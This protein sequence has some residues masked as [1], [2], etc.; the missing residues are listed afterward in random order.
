MLVI[1]SKI[2]EQKRLARFDQ[3]LLDASDASYHRVNKPF[4]AQLRE[5]LAQSRR[6]HVGRERQENGCLRTLHFPMISTAFPSSLACSPAKRICATK[7]EAACPLVILIPFTVSAIFFTHPFHHAKTP[8]F[9][10]KTLFNYAPRFPRVERLA[11]ENVHVS[12]MEFGE[13]VDRSE[14]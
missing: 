2:A 11:R 8:A 4:L 3:I 7:T 10:R 14:E 5:Q 13:S 9:R 12:R 6:N 1:H